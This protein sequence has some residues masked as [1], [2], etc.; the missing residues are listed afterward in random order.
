MPLLK[1]SVPKSVFSDVISFA[2]PVECRY[3]EQIWRWFSSPGGLR[4]VDW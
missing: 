1:M 3:W 2:S 4:R